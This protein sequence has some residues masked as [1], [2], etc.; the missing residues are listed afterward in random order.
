MTLEDVKDAVCAALD[1]K[2]TVILGATSLR[3]EM[4]FSDDGSLARVELSAKHDFT[5][6]GRK[7][8]LARYKF[9]D[10]GIDLSGNT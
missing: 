7:P 9:G 10:G 3:V 6:R 2:S 4:R 8:E 5:V 1:R